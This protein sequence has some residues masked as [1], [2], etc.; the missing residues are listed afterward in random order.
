MPHNGRCRSQLVPDGLE[1]VKDYRIVKDR[2]AK[3]GVKSSQS[4]NPSH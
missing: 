3:T 1:I 2:H 4:G